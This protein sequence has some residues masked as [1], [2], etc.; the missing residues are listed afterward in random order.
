MEALLF[1]MEVVLSVQR[2]LF[3]SRVVAAAVARTLRTDVFQEEEEE[4]Q[5]PSIHIVQFI[6]LEE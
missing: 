5:L 4:E 2:F 1:P 6:C 3:R